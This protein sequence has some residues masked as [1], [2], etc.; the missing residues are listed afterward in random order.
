MIRACNFNPEF[1]PEELVEIEDGRLNGKYDM[2]P[3]SG[4]CVWTDL[5]NQTELV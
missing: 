4:Y 3:W 2:E 5:L 1:F